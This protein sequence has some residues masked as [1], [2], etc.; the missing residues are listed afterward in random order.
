MG[1]TID[2]ASLKLKRARRLRRGAWLLV[3]IPLFLFIFLCYRPVLRLKTPMPPDFAETNP[4]WDATRQSAE[5]RAAQA[6]W[7]LAVNIVQWRFGYGTELPAVPI[8]EFRLQIVDFPR[9]SIAAAPATRLKYW[10]K[11]RALWPQRNRWVRVY[12]WNTDWLRESFSRFME[13]TR[14]LPERLLGGS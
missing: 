7:T 8:E 12:V 4:Q 6:Y 14:R 9:D 13:A 2:G 5:N 10:N 11:L 3:L 1:G